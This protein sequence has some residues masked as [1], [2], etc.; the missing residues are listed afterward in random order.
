MPVGGPVPGS[1]REV[2][3]GVGLLSAEM[4]LL[5]QATLT[6]R[7]R[8]LLPAGTDPGRLRIYRRTGER[9]VGLV[10]YLDERRGMVEASITEL[11]EFQL[12]LDEIGGAVGLAGE[13]LQQNHPNPF[14]GSTSIRYSVSRPSLV[15]LYVVN[16][17]GQRVRTLVDRVVP[18]GP[19][20]VRWDGRSGSGGEVASGVYLLV[21]RVDGRIYTRKA[22]LIR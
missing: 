2:V 5:R 9:W 20:I 16:I 13:A 21:M 15:E 1:A 22:L 10:T 14:N 18:A 17:R 7:F 19:H 4:R 8:S 3:T 12:R 11:G 6:F